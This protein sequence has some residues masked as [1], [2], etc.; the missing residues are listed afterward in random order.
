MIS[1]WN[2]LVTLAN[3]WVLVDSSISNSA[4]DYEL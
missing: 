3:M 2:A 1:R 4:I